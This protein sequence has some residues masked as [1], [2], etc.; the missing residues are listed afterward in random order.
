MR[1]QADL[2]EQAI[3]ELFKREKAYTA[4]VHEY[5]EAEHLYK[6]ARAHAY[7]AADGTVADRNAIADLECI[8]EYQCKIKAEATLAMTKVLLED[9]RNVLSARQSIL[10][11]QSKSALAVDLHSMKQT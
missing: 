4:A 6:E 11:A 10:S 7:L 9:C 5:T 8:K 1:N 3:S 2:I